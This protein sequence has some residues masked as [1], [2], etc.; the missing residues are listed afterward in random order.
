MT[1]AEP[2]RVS[3][4]HPDR[5]PD[6]LRRSAESRPRVLASPLRCASVIDDLASITKVFVATVALDH[7]ARGALTLD[8]PLTPVVPEWRGTDHAPITLRRI[9]S[10]D[11]GFKSG[12]DYRTLLDK[13]SAIG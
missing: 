7:V 5:D 10:H 4:R 2:E 1:T 3:F 6:F 12:A 13:N 9:L 11:A 8:D